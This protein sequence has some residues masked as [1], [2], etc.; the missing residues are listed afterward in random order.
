MITETQERPNFLDSLILPLFVAILMWTIHIIS[1]VGQLDFG[2][3]GVYPQHWNGIIGIF[4]APFIH[5]D[6]THLTSNTFPFLFLSWIIIYF[7][8]EIAY[9]SIGLIYILTGLIVWI[10]ARPVY[11]IGAS[12]VVYGLVA[13][14]F[15]SGIFV[16]DVRAIVLAL[17]VTMLYSGMFLGVLPN[18]EGISWESHLYGGIIGI[19][20]AFLMRSRI[21]KEEKTEWVEESAEN[22]IHFLPQDTFEKTKQQRAEEAAILNQEWTW[23]SDSTE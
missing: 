4:T 5:G 3:L 6:W 16:K 20:V 15:W 14:V 18:Q 11:H 21:I 2:F 8:N 22:L 13:F 7:Y 9:Q 10:F 1:F 23:D 19:V 12:G 17:I